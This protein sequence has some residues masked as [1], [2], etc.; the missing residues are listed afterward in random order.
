MASDNDFTRTEYFNVLFF[1][2]PAI[3]FKK[4]FSSNTSIQRNSDPM[5]FPL[6]P[7]ITIGSTVFLPRKGV[8]L[9]SSPNWPNDDPYNANGTSI[10]RSPDG[11]HIKLVVLDLSLQSGCIYDTVRL[12]D[13]KRRIYSV[14]C[15]TM[16]NF[17]FVG[18]RKISGTY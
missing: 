4:V 6:F 7:V 3:L 13:G 16:G 12:Y 9:I 2:S 1:F 18:K 17:S 8:K 15:L 11:S 5:Q 14:A 10:I